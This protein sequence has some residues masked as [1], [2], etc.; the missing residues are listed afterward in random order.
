MPDPASVFVADSLKYLLP[1]LDS[2]LL[3]D[4]EYR[5]PMQGKSKKEQERIRKQIAA[6]TQKIT[7]SDKKNLAIIE[8]IINKHGWLGQKEIGMKASTTMFMVIQHA[9]LKSQER[10]LP[11]L[12]QALMEK[13]LLAANY[14]ML[15]DR[16]EVKNK[17]PQIFGTQIITE[18]GASHIYPLLNPD[19]VDVWRKSIGMITPFQSYTKM[20]S[21]EWDI[22]A[23]KKI[24][25]E[26]KRR[27]KVKDTS[28]PSL[29]KPL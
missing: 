28:M 14:A 9:D 23:Y 25:P 2:V 15:I 13:K 7:E 27:Y 22:E 1:I 6:N 18:K 21:I 11:I 8:E 20:F 5:I 4:Q 10:Y 3:R 24:L 16:I 19:S 29:I 12:R 17:R 26:L